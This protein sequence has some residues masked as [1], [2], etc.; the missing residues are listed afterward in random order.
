MEKVP[1]RLEKL[2]EARRT[3]HV[4]GWTPELAA[5]ECRVV[6]VSLAVPEFLD[7][8]LV[9]PVVPEVADE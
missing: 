5:D 1:R 7:E 8:D 2:R 3:S 4:F 9:A 6:D